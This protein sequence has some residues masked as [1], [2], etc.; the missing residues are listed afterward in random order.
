M[1]CPEDRALGY[2]AVVVVVAIV[3]GLVIGAS[4]HAMVGLRVAL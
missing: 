4:L 1:H 2:T 3:L